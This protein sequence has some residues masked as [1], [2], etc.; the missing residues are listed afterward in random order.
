MSE[1]YHQQ[2]DTTP[3]PERSAPEA[4]ID[5]REPN[6]LDAVKA[7]MVAT[8]VN[9]QMSDREAV[10]LSD[11]KSRADTFEAHAS[12]ESL[13]VERYG[14]RDQNY[15]H[16]QALE[17]SIHGS[18]AQVR[19]VQK[20][21]NSFVDDVDVRG[22]DGRRLYDPYRT[23]GGSHI[24][25]RETNVVESQARL[26]E[27]PIGPWNKVLRSEGAGPYEALVF[28]DTADH[29]IGSVRYAKFAR[30]RSE[31]YGEIAK[32]IDELEAAEREIADPSI[33]EWRREGLQYEVEQIK[34]RI[35]GLEGTDS[36]WRQDSLKTIDQAE[37]LEGRRLVQESRGLSE[38]YKQGAEFYRGV[39]EKLNDNL[40][41]VVEQF[42]DFYDLAPETFAEK[43]SGEFLEA[44]KEYF[45][46]KEDVRQAERA[47][48]Y[49]TELVGDYEYYTDALRP[50]S[51]KD[52]TSND[53]S[54]LNLSRRIAY[55]FGFNASRD[56]NWQEF[57]DKTRGLEGEDLAKMINRFTYPANA[58]RTV[59]NL[60]DYIAFSLKVNEE[61]LDFSPRQTLE[62]FTNYAKGLQAKQQLDL[63]QKQHKLTQLIA[64]FKG[65]QQEQAEQ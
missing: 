2:I 61:W 49:A 23:P 46:M 13:P 17:E 48:G 41:N 58:L 59:E 65:D 14:V 43:T 60:M 32:E 47:A 9:D 19:G 4:Q 36:P 44:A 15:R 26:A 64:T 18:N 55:H 39:S 20:E 27:M 24:G 8:A 53:I 30:E 57:H 7:Q 31:V 51:D 33:E 45:G 56:G 62:S 35:A 37:E 22:V 25:S 29:G 1:E 21:S 16:T 34:A 11:A 40:N 10:Q 42:E 5:S 6:E 54:V 3:V 50:D 28:T 38:Q 52:I 12:N 63:Q